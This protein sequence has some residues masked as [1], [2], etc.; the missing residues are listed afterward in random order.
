M[1]NDGLV[2][3]EIPEDGPV[4]H[5]SIERIQRIFDE[6]ERELPEQLK[7]R[8]PERAIEEINATYPDE[9]VALRITRVSASWRAIDA[10]RVFGHAP[11]WTEY[12]ELLARLRKEFPEV[13]L[14]DHYTRDLAVISTGA[15]GTHGR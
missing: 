4:H 12:Q 9:W 13:A 8:F 3:L 15:P 2:D 11:N 7:K 14:T 6:G 1:Q 10:G 5:V